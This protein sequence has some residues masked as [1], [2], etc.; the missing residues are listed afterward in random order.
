[1]FGDDRDQQKQGI[2]HHSYDIGLDFQSCFSQNYVI[3]SVRSLFWPPNISTAGLPCKH[4][5]ISLS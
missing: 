2:I 5:D 3:V 1:M 4:I